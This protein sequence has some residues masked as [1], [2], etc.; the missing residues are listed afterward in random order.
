M[1]L[2]DKAISVFS[3]DAGVRRA[4]A[5][6][7]LNEVRKFE[8]A[9]TSSRRTKNWRAKDSGSNIE[10]QESLTTL[11]ARSRQLHRDS[12]LARRITD[13]LVNNVAGKGVI[14]EASDKNFDKYMEGFTDST[15]IDHDKRMDF[16]G[17]Q[18]LLIETISQS[19]EV[20]V[21]KV[22]DPSSK[23]GI[24]F[25]IIEPDHLDHTKNE[26]YTD[27]SYAIQGVKFDSDGVIVGYWVFE[28]HPGDYSINRKNR[29]SKLFPSSEIR[30]IF[31]PKRP[32]QVRG[33][34]HIAP[35][36]INIKDV[37][38]TLNAELAR[39]K[40]ATCFAGY[41]VDTKGEAT[42]E[43]LDEI[44][45]I[46]PGTIARLGPGQDIRFSN[47]PSTPDFSQFLKDQLRI[48][49]VGSGIT[50]EQ[51]SGDLSGT[52]F[53]SSRMGRLEFDR[54][55][56]HWQATLLV[57]QFCVWIAEEF[58]KVSII[59]GKTSDDV[60]FTYT[61]PIRELIDPVAENNAMKS[62][63]RNGFNSLSE[64]IRSRGRDPKR[65]LQELAGDLK[66]LDELGLTL[67]VDPRK[68]SLAGNQNVEKE[69]ENEN[70]E[71]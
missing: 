45:K 17:L 11:R 65:T 38:D 4:R 39:R 34:P 62:E 60:S 59:K 21:R 37:S 29:Q 57:N 40:I 12:A 41:V 43:E 26:T 47:P 22:I 35:V 71:S 44:S 9:S 48:I 2:I 1:N 15:A 56:N 13:I 50:Y 67:D 18:H 42:E 8:A 68:V 20:L 5:R 25:Q 70:T 24:S 19:G 16:Y 63:I 51:L 30:H 7:V 66:L 10:I 54:L 53:S 58:K 69:E 49:A 6:I 31:D 14:I 61:P 64:V 52:N 55:I 36:M 28:D 32:G 33:F 3:P 46:A 27:G 23:Y